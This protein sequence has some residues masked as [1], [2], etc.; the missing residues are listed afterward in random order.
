MRKLLIVFVLMLF[1]MPLPAQTLIPD[2]GQVN[3][4]SDGNS[5]N[6]PNCLTNP[7]PPPGGTVFAGD[8]P[9]PLR[10]ND[11]LTTN[12]RFRYWRVSCFAGHTEVLLNFENISGDL[13]LL[14]QWTHVGIISQ[15]GR[16]GIANL[17]EIPSE[18][19]SVP[20][21][22][23]LFVYWGVGRQ[24][25]SPSYVLK[26]DPTFP[27]N[28]RRADMEGPLVLVFLTYDLE[29]DLDPFTPGDLVAQ[30]IISFTVPASSQM[31]TFPQFNAPPLT[32]RHA[33]NWTVEGTTDQGI[34]LS[35]SELPD[36]QLVASLGWFTYDAAGNAIWY[37]GS[38]LFQLGDNQID[39]NL[40][41]IEN[42][43][44]NSNQ[45]GERRVIAPASL[46]VVDCRLLVLTY[47]LTPEGLDARSVNLRRLFNGE[48]AGY[49]CRNLQDRRESS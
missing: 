24:S 7:L 41:T 8:A 6:H 43:H 2:M 36:R 37:T 21:T 16:T 49:P 47:D 11:L 9:F 13:D 42:G 25:I 40:T 10:N 14:P 3:F 18:F 4:L 19:G 20:A 12:V 46:R 35:I 45:A 33:G 31:T 27:T 38:A 5:I 22:D 15:S 44:F 29:P 17:Y 1:F 32:G 26:L 28:L 48:I 23:S 34:V 30:E 39:F